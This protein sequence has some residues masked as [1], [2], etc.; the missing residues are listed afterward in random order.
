M[1]HI[2]T[3]VHHLFPMSARDPT[4]GLPPLGFISVD[5]HFP[6]PPGDPFNPQS[7]PFPLIH[8][9]AEGSTESQ[10]VTGGKY[11]DALIDRFV[12]AGMRLAERSCVGIITSCGFVVM[13]QDE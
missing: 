1:S 4:E 7:W 12:D 11:D 8:E 2:N 3:K 13:A 5:V 9:R 10:I 6:R